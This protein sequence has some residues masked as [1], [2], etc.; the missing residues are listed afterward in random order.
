[1]VQR[2]R[3]RATKRR[4]VTKRRVKTGDK[5]FRQALQQLKRLKPT[6]RCQALKMA[7]NAFIRKMCAHIKKLR[8]RKVTSKKAKALRRHGKALRLLSNNS[9]PISTK[10]RILTQRGGIFPLLAPILM[11]A[12]GPALG[13][14]AGA[15]AHKII[16]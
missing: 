5:K 8:F 4:H 7:N 2:S 1:M 9:T 14:L 3:K 6:H 12:A 15:V 10:R 13:G 11:A 16:N